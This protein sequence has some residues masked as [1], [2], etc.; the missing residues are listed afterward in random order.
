MPRSG[1]VS[2][3]RRRPPTRSEVKSVLRCISAALSWS[4]ERRRAEECSDIGHKGTERSL[5]RAVSKRRVGGRGRFAGGDQASHPTR[6]GLMSWGIW[7]RWWKGAL[8]SRFSRSLPLVSPNQGGSPAS[9]QDLDG[10]RIDLTC[11]DATRHFPTSLTTCLGD[12]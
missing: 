2:A 3:W 1:C 5:F 11:W 4:N 8:Y 7:L 12:Q 10:R 6:T 9:S